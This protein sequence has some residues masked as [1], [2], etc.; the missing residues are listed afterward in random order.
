MTHVS[1][2]IHDPNVESFRGS[3]CQKPG[4]HHRKIGFAGASTFATSP[5]CMQNLSSFCNVAIWPKG[6]DRS[7]PGEKEL[8]S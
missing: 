5:S 4:F 6:H 7:P 3:S 1:Y 8:L 2:S